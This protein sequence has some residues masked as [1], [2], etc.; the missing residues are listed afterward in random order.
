MCLRDTWQFESKIMQQFCL[1][2]Q[3][4]RTVFYVFASSV[5]AGITVS[6]QAGILCYFLQHHESYVDGLGLKFVFVTF[7]SRVIS[8]CVLVHLLFYSFSWQQPMCMCGRKERRYIPR[9]LW[10]LEVHSHIHKSPPPVNTL[11]KSIH[12]SAHHIFDRRSLLP[13][14]PG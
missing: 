2:C 13:S 9:I 4:N 10:N 8:Y 7:L 11:A 12:S 14:W 5:Y 3:N 6:Y 1:L